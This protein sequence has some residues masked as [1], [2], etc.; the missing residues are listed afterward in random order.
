MQWNKPETRL[1][2][3]RMRPELHKICPKNYTSDSQNKIAILFKQI[4]KFYYNNSSNFSKI[5]ANFHAKFLTVNLHAQNIIF[6]PINYL[7]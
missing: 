3:N 7:L 2:C 4:F 6:P 1:D 5:I